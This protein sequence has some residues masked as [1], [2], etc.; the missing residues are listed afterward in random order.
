TMF[1]RKIKL[2]ATGVFLAAITVASAG[3]LAY[4]TWA[5]SPAEPAPQNQAPADAR[6]PARQEDAVAKEL[7]ALQG[8]WKIV[9]IETD[10]RKASPDELKGMRWTFKGT[11]LSGSDPREKE[12]E[13]G[14]IRLDPTKTPKQIDL[15]SLEGSSKGKTMPGI[16]KLENGRLTV[17]L[18]D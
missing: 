4:R 15:T 18:R 2:M 13:I 10:S 8:D 11:R 6:K 1:G 12:M 3:A 7:K 5:R 16:Y 14:E 9:G 17:C